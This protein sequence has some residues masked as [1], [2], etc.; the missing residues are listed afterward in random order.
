LAG[1]S[2]PP[3]MQGRSFRALL[4]KQESYSARSYIFSERNWHD[5]DEHQRAVRSRRFKLIRT[6]AYSGLPLCVT[7]DIAASPSFRA[8]R[9]R[10]EARR[11][12]PAQQRLFESPRAR[13]ELYD[14][15][16]DPWELRNVAADPR[17]A[18]EVEKLAGV[19][20]D[21]MEQSDDFPAAYRVRDDN[22]DR[23]T[24]MPFTTKIP[25]LRNTDLPP[26]DE[27]WGKRQSELGM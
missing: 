21:W 2:P 26:P 16:R 13:L 20:Q 22:T 9:M 19:L 12:N 8:L 25:P 6:D 17:Y 10:A 7:A 4:T 3:S 24:G 1:G 11:L 15:D 27:R 14:L 23:I 18:Q 5:C